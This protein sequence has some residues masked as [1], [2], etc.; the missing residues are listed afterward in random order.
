MDSETVRIPNREGGLLGAS[1]EGM[2]SGNYQAGPQQ[3]GGAVPL[4][5]ASLPSPGS[6]VP[7]IFDPSDFMDIPP[8]PEG[9]LSAFDFPGLQE[10]LRPS[11]GQ[12]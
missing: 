10:P 3:Q 8:D 12:V 5:T 4:E 9:A 6:L 2:W 11:T 1:L 7:P